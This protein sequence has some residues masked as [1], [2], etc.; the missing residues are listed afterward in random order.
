MHVSLVS[1][2]RGNNVES[3]PFITFTFD[4]VIATTATDFPSPD[5]A[6]QFECHTRFNSVTGEFGPVYIAVW[7][8]H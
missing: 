7:A 2:L 6:A 3:L 8:P 5:D 4:L 1:Q